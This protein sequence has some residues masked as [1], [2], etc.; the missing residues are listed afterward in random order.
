MIARSWRGATRTSDAEEYARYVE[1]TG[2][3]AYRKTPGYRGGWTLTRALGEQTVF[4][5][6][7]LWESEE[8][9]RA[10]AG[11]DATTAVFYPEDDR[12]LVDR[13]EEVVHWEVA[14]DARGR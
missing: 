1:F 9:V 13:D 2:I 6:L 7:S 12:F 14:L 11:E 10:F 8:A 3:A 5:V 4:L